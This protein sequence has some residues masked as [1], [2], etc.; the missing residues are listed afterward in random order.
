MSRTLQRRWK[1]RAFLVLT[2]SL[3]L[4]LSFSA[5][6]FAA[7]PLVQISSDPYTNPDSNHKTQVEPDTFAFGH[8][9][10]SVFQSGRFFDGGA[11]NIGWATSTN[12]G[13]T[14]THGF[15]PATTVNAT[16]A[17]PYPRVSDP[18]VAYDARH[19]VWLVSYLGLTDG[20]SG[21][22]DVLVSRSTDG[23]LTW[24]NPVVV[25]AAQAFF[26]KNWTVC[27]DTA[28]SPFYGHCYTEFDNAGTIN[29]VQMST[30]TNGG[31]T[32]GPAKTTPDHACVIGGQPLVQPNGTV[33]VPI[34]DCFEGTLLSFRSTDGGKSW[35]RVTLVAQLLSRFDPGAIRS[36]PLPSAE[37][38]R[39]GKV[40]VVWE[41][42]RF[43]PNCFANDI[44]MVTSTD[45]LHWTLP[46]RIPIDPVGS[47][48][49]HFIPG[50]AVDRS[51]AGH[52]AHLGLAYYYYPN[53]NCTFDT[54]Q[55]NVGFISSTNGGASW[56]SAKQLAGPM[57]LTWLPLT[58]LGFMVGDYI[59]TSIVPG[60]D[61]A[62]P[63]FAVAQAPRGTATCSDPMTGAPGSQCDEAMFTTP[64]EL[65]PIVGGTHAVRNEPTYPLTR[66]PAQIRKIA[67]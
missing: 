63:V 50:L 57:N 47:S 1:T 34:D 39:S 6:A 12:G 54:C 28:S 18:S 52:S 4:S 15:L 44:V 67:N 13:Q 17:G 19:K 36:G 26:D 25:D 22:V 3:F 41:D 56:S 21:P 64:A 53:I 9:I 35:S 27:D 65:L 58:T 2:L 61:D 20:E 7:G 24:G 16:P 23:G 49:D 66:A 10:V 32:W 29:L 38:D 62:F 8:T 43:E 60:T 33:I 40:Y 48:V 51:T 30:S 37:I 46:R 11:S 5:V 31:L 55:L 42:C 14:W 59:S 45:G